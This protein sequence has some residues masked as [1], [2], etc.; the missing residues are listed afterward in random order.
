[1]VR[2]Y[3]IN[4]LEQVMQIWL[5][6]NIEA[7]DFITK[8]YWEGNYEMVKDIMLAAKEL[9]INIFVV[10]Q[11]DDIK[12][13]IGI[14]KGYIEGLFIKKDNQGQGM[15]RALVEQ[16]KERFDELSLSVYEKNKD[17]IAFYQRQGFEIVSKG[18]NEETDEIEF[19]MKF[20]TREKI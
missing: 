19:L 17:A 8:T 7:H 9:G 10:E 3:N 18:Y 14:R 12:G 1:M 5:Q 13:F 16:A 4:D 6:A 2:N 11:D 20:R 15:G